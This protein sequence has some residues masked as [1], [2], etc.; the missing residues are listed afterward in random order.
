MLNQLVDHL[1]AVW[2]IKRTLVTNLVQFH[3]DLFGENCHRI[4]TQACNHHGTQISDVVI[5]TERSNPST[6]AVSSLDNN[7]L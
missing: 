4:P 3:V 7:N 1:C 5:F 6:Y 2:F